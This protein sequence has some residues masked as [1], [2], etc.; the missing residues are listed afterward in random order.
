MKALT[1]HSAKD[2]RLET[3]PDPVL[4]QDD[5]IIHN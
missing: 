2:V 4:Q 3:V 1:C 5:D